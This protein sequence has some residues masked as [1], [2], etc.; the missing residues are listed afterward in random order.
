[1]KERYIKMMIN[2]DFANT[3]LT[4]SNKLSDRNIPHT[5][6]V[7]HDGLQ[8]RFPWNDGDII[9]HNFSFGHDYG[10][11]ESMGCPWDNKGYFK[12]S[13]LD[14]EEA[15]NLITEWYAIRH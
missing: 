4:L 10:K 3:I 15:L 13:C 5:L 11:V 6:N 9:C 7:I 14:I 1:M 2:P 8:I 12:V